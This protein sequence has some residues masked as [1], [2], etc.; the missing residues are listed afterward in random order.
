[1]SAVVVSANEREFSALSTEELI[2]RVVGLSQE[3]RAHVVGAVDSMQDINRGIHL[4]SMNARIEAARAGSAGAGFGVVGQ[5]LTRMSDN[6]REAAASLIRESQ[7]RGVD[8]DA[9]LRLLNEDVVANRLCDLAYSAIDIVDRNLYERSCDVRW[10][11]TEPAVARCLV[12]GTPES[13][14]HA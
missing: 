12:E 8:L 1:M 5:E 13:L 10:W 9:V 14:R 3:M 6:M 7:A 2:A 4:L 11:A